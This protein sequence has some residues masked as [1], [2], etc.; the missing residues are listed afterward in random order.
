RVGNRT[1]PH[2]TNT[3][4]GVVQRVNI[5]WHVG[6]EERHHTACV[7]E[8]PVGDDYVADLCEWKS[9]VVQ[10]SGEFKAAASIDQQWFASL[11]SNEHTS[12]GSRYMQWRTG[13]K[14]D[15]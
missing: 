13:A 8:V 4:K 1:G 15:D 10:T 7:I 2:L 5:E 6:H 14:K 11:C 12:H 3:C 9:S